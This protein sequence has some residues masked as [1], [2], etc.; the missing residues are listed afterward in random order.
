MSHVMMLTHALVWSRALV[1]RHTLVM[2]HAWIVDGALLMMSHPLLR[3]PY[4]TAVTSVGVSHPTRA[5]PRGRG[6][7][8]RS[9]VVQVE[10]R[11]RCT[12]AV[13]MMR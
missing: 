3:I 4:T 8:H 9:R 6:C 2:S 1:V 13:V 5:C 10:P 11:G 12:V 7:V